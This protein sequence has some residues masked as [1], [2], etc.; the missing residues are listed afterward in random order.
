MPHPQDP[1]SELN[2]KESSSDE[3]QPA[4]SEDSHEETSSEEEGCDSDDDKMP[5][6]EGG[7]CNR[8]ILEESDA[9]SPRSDTNLMIAATTG[10]RKL[11]DMMSEEKDESKA[12][13]EQAVGLKTPPGKQMMK[14]YGGKGALEDTSDDEYEYG[15]DESPKE[16]VSRC[17]SRGKQVVINK[18]GKPILRKNKLNPNKERLRQALAMG[19]F[20]NNTAADPNTFR[21]LIGKSKH[22]SEVIE[23]ET[24][25]FVPN[26]HFMVRAIGVTDASTAPCVLLTLSFFFARPF[27]YRPRLLECPSGRIFLFS[28]KPWTLL[29]LQRQSHKWESTNFFRFSVCRYIIHELNQNNRNH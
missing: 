20:E 11:V 18:N 24:K 2:D 4:E 21:G 17:L 3:G 5:Q 9:E 15:S 29:M 8:R 26:L 27:K 19:F 16:K 1:K 13:S 6:R 12:N 14:T 28:R 22:I 25:D 7:A 23:N 10:K